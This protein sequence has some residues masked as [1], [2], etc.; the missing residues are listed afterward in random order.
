MSAQRY[1]IKL[2][3]CIKYVPLYALNIQLITYRY[4][5]VRQVRNDKLNV[6]YIW[7]VL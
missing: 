4:V 1:D 7:V 2:I 3:I 5:Q 6:A